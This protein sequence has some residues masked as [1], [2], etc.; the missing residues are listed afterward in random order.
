MTNQ[1]VPLGSDLPG[2]S[3]RSILKI[4][5]LSIGLAAIMAACAEDSG[6]AKPA[7]VGDAAPA[8]K[9]P[10]VV[11]NDGVLWRTASSLHYSIIDAHNA[12]KE[13]GK[14]NA[15]QTDIVN[16]FIA[17]NE[18]AIAT[19]D[20]LTVDAG[21]EV[22]SCANPRF[23]RVILVPL[24]ARITGRPKEGNE[25]ADVEPSD[26]PTRDALGLAY[27]MEA[28][29][30]S[31]HQSL[32]PLFT[33]PALRADAMS[34][35][36]AAARRAA[37]LALAINPANMLNPALIASAN[38][39]SPTTLNPST[40]QQ[41]YAVPG[42]F[43]A[44]AATQLMIGKVSEADTQFTVNIETPAANSFVYDGQTC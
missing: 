37:A 42:Q 25:E 11:V 31:T 21:G 24:I 15:A 39:S 30:A 33:E 2:V 23:D 27:S 36:Q 14:L 3:R 22:F 19:L 43:G 17:A 13:H 32:V 7:R 18:E 26:D 40:R 9:L 38:V 35:G 12:A 44:L 16:A 28:V 10:T 20:K 29:A 8:S 5:G 1:P 6:D 41:H 34:L 4:G